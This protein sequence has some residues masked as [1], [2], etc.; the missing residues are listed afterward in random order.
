MHDRFR[1]AHCTFFQFPSHFSVRCHK[2]SAMNTLHLHIETNPIYGLPNTYLSNHVCAKAFSSYFL[3]ITRK[4]LHCFHP[5][6]HCVLR[7][8]DL[9][10]LAR[11]SNHQGDTLPH[12]GSHPL[13]LVL[14]SCCIL[15]C[16]S[17]LGVRIGKPERE[18]RRSGRRHSRPT[19]WPS[20]APA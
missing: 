15:P 4:K 13:T 20:T 10:S 14:A 16:C 7:I 17:F 12:K 18:Y 1:N 11:T 2:P 6:K 8:Q 9:D 5:I 3:T 19:R